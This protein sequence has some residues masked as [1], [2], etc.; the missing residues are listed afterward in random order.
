MRIGA[1]I[2]AAGLSTRMGGL[3]PLLSIGPR[4][5]LGHTITLFQT[6][7]IEDIIVVTGHQSD[8]LKQEIKVY[9]C[10]SVVNEDFI[11]GMFSS[12]QAGVNALNPS[13]K[14]FFLLPVD[15]PLVRKDTV[16]QL[17]AA[18]NQDRSSLVFYPVHR[19]RRGH[20]PL[21][22]CDLITEILNFDDRG[23]LRALLKRYQQ[24]ACNVFVSDPY[25]LLDADTPEDLVLLSAEY[26][27]DRDK[28][29]RDQ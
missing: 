29:N 6:S 27:K 8:E 20:P 25:I 12:I 23:D 24:H 26:M 28:A 17:M 15:I 21:I 16:L 11:D 7:G 18:M 13:D 10:R 2:L 14:A 3:K 9:N 4:T 5:L 19:S 22:K 1:I